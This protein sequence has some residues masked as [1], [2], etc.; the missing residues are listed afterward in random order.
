MRFFR[1]GDRDE[2]FDS[3]GIQRSEA[4]PDHSAIG[5]AHQRMESQDSRHIQRRRDHP[6]LII[7][8]GRRASRRVGGEIEAENA[9]FARIDRAALR[10]EAGPPAGAALLAPTDET[11]ARYASQCQDGGADGIAGDTQPH[12]LAVTSEPGRKRN[13]KVAMAG[14]DAQHASN[15]GT[16]SAFRLASS[17]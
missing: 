11:I 10:D 2:L 1:G 13:F 9:I 4:E 16:R 8:R 15:A 3:L 14:V 5:G 17:S 12:A 6:G 7:G